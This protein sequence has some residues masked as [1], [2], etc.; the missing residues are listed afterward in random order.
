MLNFINFW[1][2]WKA[3]KAIIK[4]RRKKGKF[5]EIKNLQKFHRLFFDCQN[6]SLIKITVERMSVS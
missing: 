4:K 3:W 6:Q 2:F 5:I 1:H